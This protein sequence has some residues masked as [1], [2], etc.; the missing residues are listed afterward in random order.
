MVSTLTLAAQFPTTVQGSPR[1]PGPAFSR[2]SRRRGLSRFD[3]EPAAPTPDQVTDTPDL[4]LAFLDEWPEGVGDRLDV[5]V[6]LFRLCL[7]GKPLGESPSADLMALRKLPVGNAPT[8]S[9]G[10]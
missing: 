1:N 4:E 10:T 9:D 8:L 5:L 7:R 6:R 3:D 2:N